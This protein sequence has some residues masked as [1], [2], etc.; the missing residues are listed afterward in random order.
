MN[1]VNNLNNTDNIN[2]PKNCCC[3][4]YYSILDE[5]CA[6]YTFYDEDMEPIGQFQITKNY[7]CDEF[8]PKDYNP[9][10]V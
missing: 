6:Y 3:D 10:E 2:P 1:D 5:E 8:K 9:F 4:C 7:S